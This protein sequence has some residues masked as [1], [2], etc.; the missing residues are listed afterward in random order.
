MFTECY[1]CKG[2]RV[3]SFSFLKLERK[4]KK[5]KPWVEPFFAFSWLPHWLVISL[6]YIKWDSTEFFLNTILYSYII[7]LYSYTILYSYIREKIKYFQ[8]FKSKPVVNRS[9]F[10]VK[11]ESCA[12]LHR[13]VNQRE[14]A[15]VEMKLMIHLEMVIIEWVNHL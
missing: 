3:N 2:S 6:I 15:I 14:I 9:I 5:W 10:V 1:F 7:F 4:K 11:N 12:F 13:E 8:F